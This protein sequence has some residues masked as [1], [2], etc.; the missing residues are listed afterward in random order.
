LYSKDKADGG[1]VQINYC[2][3]T[4]KYQVTARLCECMGA[5]SLPI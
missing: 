1:K 4:T 2:N 3:A 5:V